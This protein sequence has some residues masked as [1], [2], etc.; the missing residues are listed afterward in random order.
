M[1]TYEETLR[2][3]RLGTE[4]KD[5]GEKEVILASL[6]SVFLRG[7]TKGHV[8]PS[9]FS[10]PLAGRTKTQVQPPVCSITSSCS[11]NYT[12]KR[13][14][15]GQE[16]SVDCVQCVR[17]GCMCEA[18]LG[19][20]GHPGAPWEQDRPLEAAEALGDVLLT[21]LLQL[22]GGFSSRN[23]GTKHHLQGS[24]GVHVR[25]VLAAQGPPQHC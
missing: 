3:R 22:A 14:A 24:D 12:N 15:G 5:R 1:T 17:C 10:C 16:L 2:Q 9:D 18:Q 6:P 19:S 8:L 11:T 23:T 4:K 7:I 25:S 21:D 13:E 20:T